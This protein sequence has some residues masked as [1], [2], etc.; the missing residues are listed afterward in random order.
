MGK[1]VF[2]IISLLLLVLIVGTFLVSCGTNSTPSPS[3]GQVLMQERCAL[4][5]SLDRVTSSHKTAD[6]WTITVQRMIARGAPL[7]DQEA[8]NLIAYLAANYK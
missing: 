4:C 7:T 5:H 6:Q 3:G 1:K 2:Y 8:Q